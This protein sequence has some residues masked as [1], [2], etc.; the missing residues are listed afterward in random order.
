MEKALP[1]LTRSSVLLELLTGVRR[2]IS[3]S[4]GS[5]DGPLELLLP[6]DAIADLGEAT[7]VA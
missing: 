7:L 3:D 5:S 4:R 6:G 1:L 2:A